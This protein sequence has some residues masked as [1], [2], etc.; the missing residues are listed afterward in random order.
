MKEKLEKYQVI[1]FLVLVV[2]VMGVIKIKYGYKGGGDAEPITMP[3][4]TATEEEKFEK[5]YPLWQ[6]LPYQGKGFVAEKYIDIRTLLVK[7]EGV[8]ESVAVKAIGMWLEGLGEAGADH[9][10]QFD[11]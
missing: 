9:K 4:P 7:A 11:K 10:I 5:D 6:L 3:T 2:V 8:G 1:V